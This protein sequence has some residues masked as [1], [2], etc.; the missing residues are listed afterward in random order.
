M[1]GTL[2]TL[3]EGPDPHQHAPAGPRPPCRCAAVGQIGCGGVNNNACCDH[4]LT[5]PN[6][7]FCASYGVCCRNTGGDCASDNDC[8]GDT[9]VGEPACRSGK[10]C[11][12]A[13]GQCGAASDCCDS[14]HTCTGGVCTAP[15]A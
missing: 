6:Q 3:R 1:C 2:P 8:C 13:G 15:P 14:T 9:L 11:K 10:C 4:A 5:G 7:A 12:L